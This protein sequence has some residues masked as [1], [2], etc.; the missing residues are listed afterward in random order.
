[1]ADYDLFKLNS[2]EFEHLTQS[3]A[4]R[5]LGPGV[6]PFGDGPDGG[7]EATFDGKVPFPNESHPWDGYGVLQAKF[8]Q[9]SK[10]TKNDGDWVIAQLESELNEYYKPDTK[11][12][13][14]EYFIFVTNVV[15]TPVADTGS[16][17]KVLTRL[18]EFRDHYGLKGYAL[19]DYDKIRSLLD[20]NEDVRRAYIPF[21][22]SGDVLALVMEMMPTKAANFE[23][24]LC[25]FL[26][27]ELLSDEFVNLEQAG[28]G[29][30]ESI[31]LARVFVD[32]HTRNQPPTA[33]VQYLDRFGRPIRTES[34][35]DY[36]HAGF[37]KQILEVASERLDPRTLAVHSVV[38]NHESG[39]SNQSRGRFVLIGGPGQGKTTVGQFICQIFRAS[40]VAQRPETTLSPE[41]RSALAMI[42]T[43]CEEEEIDSSPVPRFPFR[44][45]LNEF[46]SA[47]SGNS[48]WPVY[49][50]FS[51]LAHQ[52]HK[53]TD[54]E[55]SVDDVKQW[56]AHY[57]SLFIFDG[58][59]EVP[60]SSNRDQVLKSIRE[61]WVDVN[62]LNADVLAIATSRPQGYNEDFS[63][64]YYQHQWLVHLDQQLGNHFA[65]RLVD[66]RYGTD[67]DRKEKVLAR[68]K[69]AF[70]S[71]S[72]SRL[73]RTPLQVTIMTALVD[74]MGQPPQ[75]RWNLFKSYYDVIYQ[76]EVER[77]IPASE[78]LRDYQPDI[79]TIHHRVGLLLQID[80][81]RSG[82]TD[83][84]FSAQRF[85]SLVETRLKEEGHQGSELDH[86]K[87]RI[88]DAA[89]ERLVFLVGLESDQIGFEIRSL[90][91]FMAAESLM[92]GS[93]DDID[94][95]LSEIAP[96]PNWRNVFLFASGKCFA[97]RQHLRDKI[98]S[99]CSRMNE[100]DED[101]VAG[102]Y[103]VGSDLAIELI[104]DGLSRHQ[105][106]YVQSFARIALRALDAPN[107]E[108]HEQL[109]AIYE[110]Q[111]EQIYVEELTR[112][113]NDSRENV[114]INV[115]NC[116]LHL[117]NSE[118]PWA[119]DLTT[120]Y[121]PS[122][123]EGQLGLLGK[124][125]D[126]PV[127]GWA[128][129]KVLDLA[130]QI[131]LHRF[132]EF[133]RISPFQHQGLTSN[134]ELFLQ[135]LHFSR[136]QTKTQIDFLGSK[137]NYFPLSTLSDNELS[138]IQQFSEMND[139]H[140]SWTIYKCAA[141]FLKEPTKESLARGL[142]SV[143]N[144]F[145]QGISGPMTA[146]D[147]HIPWPLLACLEMCTD[148]T[149]VLMLA[150]KAASG[151]LGDGD[152]WIQAET[153]WFEKGITSDDILS[154]SDD[155]LPFDAHIAS[156]GF[157]TT[158][159]FWP[160]GFIV[161][162]DPLLPKLIALHTSVPHSVSRKFV[163][164]LADTFFLQASFAWATRE[165]FVPDDLT[166][167]SI[168]SIYD[169][170]PDGHNIPLG[171]FG[172]LTKCP[173]DE[174]V[175]FVARYE[176]RNMKILRFHPMRITI[177]EHVNQLYK[178][179]AEL[180]DEPILL[181]IL[182][183]LVEHG[184]LPLDAIKAPDIDKLEDP[185]RK[186][187]ALLI[188][189][190]K[191]EWGA[192]SVEDVVDSVREMAKFTDDFYQRFFNTIRANRLTSS[193]LVSCVVRLQDFLLDE[194]HSASVAHCELMED[195]L[196]RRTS[197]FNDPVSGGQFNF[198]GGLVTL[199]AN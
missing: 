104:D 4:E 191:E 16:K 177:A 86:L 73:M 17:D 25:N 164:R 149:Q 124:I 59:D 48:G 158:L 1:M 194:N 135:T 110:P 29:A 145:A 76:R 41:T 183:S 68:L 190:S 107:T 168:R 113:F 195:L 14:P 26:Q 56:L 90:Q 144:L 97:D 128:T 63:P 173:I 23:E 20:N 197:K 93:D 118:V 114:R 151:E 7:R 142:R 193:H 165:H 136:Q 96:I 172:Y 77:N 163:A 82:L 169:D 15:L 132:Q 112:R 185:N 78:L 100:K 148:E 179:L 60:S 2:R 134:Q 70:E 167:D 44:I 131:P 21:V 103:L 40:I 170:L 133:Y 156:S 146:G 88:V 58:L 75:A 46:A 55:V 49:S 91:E 147:S 28:H 182:G 186:A 160:I 192:L 37:I 126:V 196:R 74:R 102:S 72:T 12:T 139:L 162:E 22:T 180:V 130:P 127:C 19:W 61:F 30:D 108:F 199:F 8:L 161:G 116:L 81:E 111:L 43:H 174:I 117:I 99:I 84:K 175:D 24:S 153:R 95:R 47:L 187:A 39:G 13:I 166:A 3:L 80:S 121:W 42:Q 141:E 51:Y 176:P 32:L 6:N 33:H 181:P 87:Q 66:V 157:P 119:Y 65:A 152:D 189:L 52:I 155:R 120:T 64:E 115:W 105:P 92:E 184:D 71:D 159:G 50:V 18:R 27:K 35:P 129:K 45:V 122:D 5:V 79:N 9:R 137:L 123:L 38:Q 154:M 138:W 171:V 198:P 98:L 188:K 150:D 69:R 34:A 89:L 109:A 57:P 106:K 36:Q 94:S 125:P 62:N 143:A 67:A 53:R 178:R 31:P 101:E 85:I 10:G 54:R 140:P 11:R 83:A